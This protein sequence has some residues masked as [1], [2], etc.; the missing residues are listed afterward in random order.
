[1]TN[2]IIMQI[3]LG[4]MQYFPDDMTICQTEEDYLRFTLRNVKFEVKTV[5][6]DNTQILRFNAAND[7]PVEYEMP[8]RCGKYI[9]S[10]ITLK[11]TGTNATYKLSKI[12]LR[13]VMDA[14]GP[15]RCMDWKDII[16][17]IFAKHI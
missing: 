13:K 5:E 17:S 15:V 3:K 4:L 7:E 2:P 10:P 1:M 8:N 11:S 14:P 9:M 16:K 6:T 12:I